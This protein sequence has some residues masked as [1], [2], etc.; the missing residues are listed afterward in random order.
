MP[1]RFGPSFA[2]YEVVTKSKDTEPF[3]SGLE[4]TD[5]LLA[6]LAGCLKDDK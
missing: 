1:M 2:R 5:K 6:E 4:A 3:V